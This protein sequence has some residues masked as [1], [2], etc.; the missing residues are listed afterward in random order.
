MA[1]EW[2][3]AGGSAGAVAARTSLPFGLALL[4]KLL[5][6]FCRLVAVVPGATV[7]S[8]PA[9]AGWWLSL[10]KL[11]RVSACQ[12]EV[13]EVLPVRRAP[14]DSGVAWVPASSP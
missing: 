14:V 11:R 5:L 4:Q 13:K 9:L 6:H 3:Q 12:V 2:G 1:A 7:A 8:L 10:Q